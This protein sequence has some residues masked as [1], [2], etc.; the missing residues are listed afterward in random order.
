MPKIRFSFIMSKWTA[1]KPVNS[2]RLQEEVDEWNEEKAA[3]KGE[4][5]VFIK[6][7]KER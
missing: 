5:A 1:E 7:R 6:Q 3:E 2:K 4:R